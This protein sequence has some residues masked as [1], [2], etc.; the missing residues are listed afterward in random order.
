M[1][2]PDY[3]L[4]I[5]WIYVGLGDLAEILFQEKSQLKILSRFYVMLILLLC[6]L[7]EQHSQTNIHTLKTKPYDVK[8]NTDFSFAVIIKHTET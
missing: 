1:D 6:K 7:S 4:Q 2:H 8:K 3:Y 5:P